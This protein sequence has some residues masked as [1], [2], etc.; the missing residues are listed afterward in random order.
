M[1]PRPT[2]SPKAPPKSGKRNGY[3]P[4]C[5]AP[6]GVTAGGLA[7]VKT[8]GGVGVC[9]FR[10]G[11]PMPGRVP[12]HHSCPLGGGG[13]GVGGSGCPRPLLD[14]WTACTDPCWRC[15]GLFAEKVSPPHPPSVH[16][17]AALALPGASGGLLRRG[18][19]MPDVPPGEAVPNPPSH[20]SACGAL[21]VFVCRAIPKAWQ[22]GVLF[23]A[24][25]FGA[26]L[27]RREC[28]CPCI[29]WGAVL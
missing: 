4:S 11:A 20:R 19:G 13:G 29:R 26:A 5:P 15:L 28:R 12:L 24:S 9:D 14:A 6:V 21:H 3:E 17:P 16:S 10:S 18:A 8:S 1:G 2:S 22:S 27:W 23:W 7:W 25:S